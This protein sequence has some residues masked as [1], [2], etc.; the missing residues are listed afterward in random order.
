[1]RGLGFWR[2]LMHVQDFNVTLISNLVSTLVEIDFFFFVLVHKIQ[3]FKRILE[4]IFIK[5]GSD[6]GLSRLTAHRQ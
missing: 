3:I 5:M 2:D 4:D 6:H 1:M